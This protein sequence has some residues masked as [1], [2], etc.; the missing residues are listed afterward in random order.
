[1]AMVALS[2]SSQI[3]AARPMDPRVMIEK[4]PCPM[5]ACS[6]SAPTSFIH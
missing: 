4:I 3:I 6:P 5:I 2:A 1:M